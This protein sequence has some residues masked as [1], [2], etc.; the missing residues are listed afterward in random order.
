[1]NL[2]KNM[3]TMNP[4]ETGRAPLEGRRLA[5]LGL[6]L[7]LCL[8]PVLAWAAPAARLLEAPAATVALINQAMA[9]DYD[10]AGAQAIQ[11][12]AAALD[13]PT[14]TLIR[15]ITLHNLSWHGQEKFTQEA[16]DTLA[17]VKDDPL[18]QMYWGS[19]ITLVAQYAIKRKDVGIAAAKAQ[20]GLAIIASAM[21]LDPGAFQMN[22]LRLL[23]GIE[24]SRQ[25]PFK[26]YENTRPNVDFLL[27]ALAKPNDLD[28]NLKSAVWLSIGDWY[29]DSKK[30]SKSLAYY[31]KAIREAPS[32]RAAAAARKIL[33]DLEG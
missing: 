25:S 11:G 31:Q 1:M 33:A 8:A 3:N 23:N 22:Y 2:H 15:G 7:I 20:E 19:A 30:V 24:I 27:A 9:G 12:S 13:E 10:E 28:K 4:K 14:R 5:P 6:A 17:S 21:K 32:G 26:Q 18:G 16:I 29:F